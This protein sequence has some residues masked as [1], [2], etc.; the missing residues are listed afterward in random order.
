[1]NF[2]VDE[3]RKLKVKKDQSVETEHCSIS[4]DTLGPAHKIKDARIITDRGVT[5]TCYARM[6]NALKTLKNEMVSKAFT[7]HFLISK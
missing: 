3:R 5:T 4:R 7:F 2:S 1:M 6:S